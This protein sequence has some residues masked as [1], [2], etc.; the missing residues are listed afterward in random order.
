MKKKLFVY[1]F[2]IFIFLNPSGNRISKIATA[3]NIHNG[4]DQ[5][6]NIPPQATKQKVIVA[7]KLNRFFLLMNN[8]TFL[9][10]HKQ[11]N[12]TGSP[13]TTTTADESTAS[14]VECSRKAFICCQ[15]SGK[16]Q[17]ES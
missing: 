15:G 9:T 3:T 6:E 5:S 14:N 10:A 13:T 17:R 7:I 11:S 4:Q 16:A 1:K 2:F 12:V 8:E